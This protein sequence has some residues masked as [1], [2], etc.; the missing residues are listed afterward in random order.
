VKGPQREVVIYDYVDRDVPVLARV[1][2]KRAAGYSVRSPRVLDY[3][4]GAR[5]ATPPF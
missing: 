2:A 1:A 3:S 5:K 4:M